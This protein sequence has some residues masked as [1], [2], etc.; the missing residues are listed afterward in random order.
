MMQHGPGL[1]ASPPVRNNLEMGRRGILFL[2]FSVVS[3]LQNAPMREWEWSVPI[4]RSAYERA[5]FVGIVNRASIA[6]GPDK[7]FSFL[8]S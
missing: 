8:P 3:S 5:Q 6:Q 7:F 4:L 1:A 2:G